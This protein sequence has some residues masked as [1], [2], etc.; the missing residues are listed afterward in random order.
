MPEGQRVLPISA[1]CVDRTDC[2]GLVMGFS[3][4]SDDAVTNAAR[5]LAISLRN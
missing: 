1:L 2:K 5:A 3:A 4:G